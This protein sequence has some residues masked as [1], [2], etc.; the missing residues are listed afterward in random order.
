VGR[1]LSGG[2]M[3]DSNEAEYCLKRHVLIPLYRPEAD[4]LDKRHI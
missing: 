4:L 1:R 2:V 3:R